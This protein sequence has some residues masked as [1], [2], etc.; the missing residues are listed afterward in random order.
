[1]LEQD[2]DRLPSISEYDVYIKLK[3]AKK[4]KSS[5]GCDV[6]IKIIKTF[7]AEISGPVSKIFKIITK[8]QKIPDHW[9]VENGIGIPKISPPESESDLRIISKTPFLSKLYES[10]VYDWLIRVVTPFL[11]PDQFGMKGSSI[12]HCLIT[13]LDFIQSSLDKNTPTAVIATFIDMSKAYNRVD[14]GLLI[15]DL[16]DMQCPGWLHRIVISFLQDRTLIFSYKGNIT[17]PRPLPGGAPQGCLLACIFFV[18]KFNSALLRPN[19]ER[20]LDSEG[21]ILMTHLLKYLLIY[22]HNSLKITSK[23]HSL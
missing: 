2:K 8:S 12:T 22:Q 23:D 17:S 21:S 10:F 9:K 13:F 14:H 1:M 3:K 18:V 15:Q 11:D 6:P 7:G 16:A 19:I 20:P 5:V 4:P